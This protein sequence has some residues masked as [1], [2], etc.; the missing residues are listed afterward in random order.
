ML[1]YLIML[2]FRFKLILLLIC[3]SYNLSGQSNFIDLEGRAIGTRTIPGS[4]NKFN[5]ME[6]SPYPIKE[7]NLATFNDSSKYKVRYNAYSDEMEV[8]INENE[9]LV[10]ENNM[11]G[12][13]IYVNEL[14]IRYIYN[15][16]PETKQNFKKILWLGEK[17]YKL[18]QVEKVDFIEAKKSNGITEPTPAK[19]SNVKKELY[20]YDIASDRLIKVPSGK[21]RIYKTIFDKKF[22]SFGNSNNL[23][24]RETKDLIQLIEEYY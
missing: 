15:V 14:N 1:L 19:F 11:E 13:E 9:I 21:N 22:K 12:Q 3:F 6:G 16:R 23:D 24:P 2:K 10:L 4:G 7:F 5:G 8:K 18:I 20:F 17:G